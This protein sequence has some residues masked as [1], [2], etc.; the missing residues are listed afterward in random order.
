MTSTELV[1]RGSLLVVAVMC[2]MTALRA[3]TPEAKVLAAGISPGTIAQLASLPQSDATNQRLTEAVG[4]DVDNVRAAAA[5][6]VFVGRRTS[7]VPALLAAFQRETQESARFEQARAITSLGGPDEERRIVERWE[8]TRDVPTL[9]GLAAGRGT[10]TLALLPRVRELTSSPSVLSELLQ[11]ATRLEPA[12]LTQVAERAR[13]RADDVLLDAVLSA[14]RA[15]KFDVPVQPVVGVLRQ[16]VESPIANVAMWHLLTQWSEPTAS[17]PP[18][19]ISALAEVLPSQ[20]D[21]GAEPDVRVVYELVSR[22]IGRPADTGERWMATLRQRSSMTS[23]RLDLPAVRALLRPDELKALAAANNITLNT[24]SAPSTVLVGRSRTAIDPSFTTV[25]GYPPGFVSSVF[26]AANC[27]AS[28][29]ARRGAGGAAADVTFGADGRVSLLATVNTAA[30]A[31][32]MEAALILFTTYVPSQETIHG[33]GQRALLMLP[34]DPEFVACHDV[35][36][37]A[38]SATALSMVP[39][40]RRGQFRPPKLTRDR[41]PVYSA[42]ALAEGVTGVVSLESVLTTTGCV[43]SMRV[44]GSLHPQLDWAAIRAVT[45][46]RL[47]PANL[48]GEPIAIVINVIVGFTMK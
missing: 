35:P 39:S 12:A 32:C 19:S 27:S 3:Q 45:G 10:S 40:K 21:A 31:A 38:G 28:G 25:G 41:K 47:T 24:P 18:A 20:L 5:R 17:L 26:K 2:A 36:L 9:F 43:R 13:D 22:A 48:D 44:V 7:L 8:V 46:W 1:R 16:G 30:S 6:V 4:H 29:A 34:F 11:L 14:A 33:N 42:Q 37:V 15:A 23:E